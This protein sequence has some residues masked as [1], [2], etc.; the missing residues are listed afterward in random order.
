MNQHTYHEAESY[1]LIGWKR[2]AVLRVTNC[3][4]PAQV[5]P[6][7]LRLGAIC[8]A[9]T[10]FKLG[11]EITKEEYAKYTAMTGRWER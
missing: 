8:Y 4:H 3:Q 5:R 7:C 10:D 11:R 9:P 1:T 6:V 2:I